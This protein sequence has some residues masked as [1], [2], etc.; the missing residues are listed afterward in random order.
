MTIEEAFAQNFQIIVT[1]SGGLLGGVA[2]LIFKYFKDVQ[3]KKIEH[4]N[5]YI[6]Q[7]NV[8]YLTWLKALSDYLSHWGIVAAKIKTYND[9]NPCALDNDD[10]NG[11]NTLLAEFDKATYHLKLLEAR[12]EFICKIDEITQLNDGFGE[13]F[14]ES[15]DPMSGQ[16]YPESKVLLNYIEETE[17]K[18]RDVL[19]LSAEYNSKYFS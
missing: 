6:K 16:I 14:I 13:H 10:I 11:G 9:D 7:L 12:K 1:L 18:V 17:K 5:E 3:L 15:Y 19:E 4:N 8:N 2:T